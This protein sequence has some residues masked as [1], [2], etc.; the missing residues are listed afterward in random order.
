M[1][2]SARSGDGA[3]E[4]LA[5]ETAHELGNIVLALRGFIEL[6]RT[7]LEPGSDQAE[8]LDRIADCATTLGEA[9][10]RLQQRGGAAPSIG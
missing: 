3:A 6:L 9:T 8:L 2:E 7:R 4:A 1:D 5:R 10:A